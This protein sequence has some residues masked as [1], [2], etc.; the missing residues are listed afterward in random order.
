[1]AYTPPSSDNVELVIKTGYTPPDSSNVELIISV[2]GVEYVISLSD[3][4]QL[5]HA[6]KKDLSLSPKEILALIDN[7]RYHSVLIKLLSDDVLLNEGIAKQVEL[8][9]LLSDDILLYET[10]DKRADLYNTILNSI[11][12]SESK[13]DKISLSL[14]DVLT[15]NELLYYASAFYELLQD[16]IGT[17]ENFNA[18][19]LIR[20]IISDIISISEQL[21]LLIGVNPRDSLFTLEKA[22]YDINTKLKE[23]VSL[24]ESA[25][26]KR[27][28]LALLS[29]VITLNEAVSYVYVAVMEQK[30]VLGLSEKTINRLKLALSSTLAL[31]EDL[32]KSLSILFTDSVTLAEV[33]KLSLVASLITDILLSENIKRDTK[34]KILSLLEIDEKVIPYVGLIPHEERLLYSLIILS[35]LLNS[36][37]ATLKEICSLIKE[38]EEA[39][40]GI[41]RELNL[42]SLIKD[43][44]EV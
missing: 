8:L 36:D 25:E 18:G 9:K 2:G 22:I 40:S 19:F 17:Q 34:I 1:M 6:D 15:L 12:I 41:K 13:R 42:Y 29:E 37:I 7:L 27:A 26:V 20:L 21:N 11:S 35:K 30:E 38:E 39:S 24:S 43:K 3:E 14:S 16:S 32:V 23:E 4:I 10:T 33:S 31:S 28:L 44:E 5:S